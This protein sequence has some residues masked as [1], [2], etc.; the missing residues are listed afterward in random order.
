MLEPCGCRTIQPLFTHQHH[1]LSSL[2]ALLILLAPSCTLAAVRAE[3]HRPALTVLPVGDGY[4]VAGPTFSLNLSRSGAITSLACQGGLVFDSAY[5]EVRD[6]TW[7][8]K[9]SPKPEQVK[10]VPPYG[11]GDN[12]KFQYYV[13]INDAAT[14]IRLDVNELV[15]VKSR[16][17]IDVILKVVPQGE[18]EAQRIAWN[19]EF[20]ASRYVGTACAWQK[21]KGPQNTLQFPRDQA[22]DPHMAAGFDWMRLNC[23]DGPV[24]LRFSAVDAQNKPMLANTSLEDLRWWNQPSFWIVD[25]ASYP[26]EN[27][28]ATQ[29]MKI[30]PGENCTLRVSMIMH[31]GE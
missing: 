9:L 7:H 19:T 12:E 30:E 18:F 29:P 26:P 1:I 14:G 17:E 3:A 2:G 11:D 27:G 4:Q 13:H 24:D 23:G 28:D 21:G 25:A 22:P 6:K 8:V 31:C 5:L 10:S 16:G 15:V 20:P